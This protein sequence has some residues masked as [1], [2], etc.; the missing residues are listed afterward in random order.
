M[1]TVALLAEA[2][3]AHGGRRT[4]YVR[5]AS[6]PREKSVHGSAIVLS[7]I[8]LA[9]FGYAGYRLRPAVQ[10]LLVRT[11]A[12]KSTAAHE[13][14]APADSSAALDPGAKAAGAPAAEVSGPEPAATPVNTGDE[15]ASGITANPPHGPESPSVNPEISSVRGK[16]EKDLQSARLSG[17]I[18]ISGV[19]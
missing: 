15:K 14:V 16:I 10:D 11:R 18:T 9:I 8:L 17:K 13:N 12:N 6:E 2:T 4:S 19:G 7:I 5:Q 3:P 1:A